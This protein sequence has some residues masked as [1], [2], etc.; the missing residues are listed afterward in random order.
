MAR[1]STNP[2][3]RAFH[4]IYAF[5]YNKKVGVILI[6]AMAILTL[7]GTLITQAPP[8]VMSQPQA[9][10]AFLE[11]M[12]G[13]YGGWTTPLSFLGFFTI[14]TSPAYL[15][16]SVLL[17]LSIIA[18]TLHRLP[19]LWR[20]AQHPRT[21]VSAKFFG[22]A[23]YQGQVP[24]KASVEEALEAARKAVQS[25]H[26]RI[27][28]DETEGS[29]GFYA[30]RHRFGP[31]GTVIAHA[32]FVIIIAAFAV[33]SLTGVDETLT[34]PVGTPQEVGH[35]TP[36]TL[37]ATSFKDT[38]DE[39]GRPTDY[40]S[41]LVLTDRNGKQLASQDVRVNTPLRYDGYK[42]HQASYGFAA[43]VKATHGDSTAYDGGLALTQRSDDNIYQIGITDL[44][45]AKTSG[46]KL[47]LVVATPA[48]GQVA[49]DVASGQALVQVVDMAG[50]QGKVLGEQVIDQGA[51]AKIGDVDV[52]FVREVPYTGITLRQD[53]GAL[54]MWIGSIL[55]VVGMAITFGA[56]HRRIWVRVCP[57]ELANDR[58]GSGR[59][60][61]A[62]T[63]VEIASVDTIDSAFERQFSSLVREVETRLAPPAS[64]PHASSTSE[65]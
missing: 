28:P 4:T 17:A 40:V 43:L 22:R 46:K 49:P 47:R 24:A 5:F 14:Y 34:L 20:K 56:R 50:S 13:R 45:P 35:G 51:T 27:L 36:Y 8:G 30:D 38:Y 44:P 58:D 62:R 2:F 37:T 1:R 33:S 3:V 10:E 18:C 12:R 42:F 65:G 53:P 41:H 55:I 59:I 21:H 6:L 25:R 19:Q 26:Y 7:L 32:A 63:V 15:A 60:R 57:G 52:T 61:A 31:F 11:Q 23:Q 29:H 39:K 54:W 64:A 48:S 16:V 9:R